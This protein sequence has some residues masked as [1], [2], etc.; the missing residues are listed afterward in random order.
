MIL[1]KREK[2]HFKDNEGNSCELINEAQKKKKP[3]YHVI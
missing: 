1:K 3:N 2:T